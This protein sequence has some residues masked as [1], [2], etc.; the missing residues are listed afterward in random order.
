MKILISA[1]LVEAQ[2]V[3]VGPPNV[4]VGDFNA[5][6]GVCP[7]SAK[8]LDFVIACPTA[9]AASGLCRVLSDMWFT[10]PFFFSLRV[11]GAA[12][13]C[14]ILLP[15]GCSACLAGMLSGLTGLN[16]PRSGRVRMSGR[17]I[18][19][20]WISCQPTGFWPCGEAHDRSDVGGFWSAW[21][22][23]AEAWLLKAH[24]LAG[25]SQSAR[26]RPCQRRWDVLYGR[27]DAARRQGPVGPVRT[28]EPWVH[29]IPPDLHGFF[30]KWSLILCGS[31]QRICPSSGQCSQSFLG[32]A[33]GPGG[34][35]RKGA[36]GLSCLVA[37]G[38]CPSFPLF[39][40][41]G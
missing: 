22:A 33:I 2:V 9:L 5:E 11:R 15:Q 28:F 21:S 41:Q 35:R 14:C 40:S 19:A 16:S 27:W 26:Q 4:I 34:C 31:A 18:V 37:S 1:F 38:F 36:L 7:C 12:L 8:D 13:D 29:W 10:P 32:S 39:A 6:P 20:N 17:C 30:L 25:G 3:G 23:G 24:L